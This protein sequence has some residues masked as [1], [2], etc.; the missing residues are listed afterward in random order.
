MPGW[1]AS[2]FLMN[3]IHAFG[4]GAA[5]APV[6]IANSPWPFQPRG[7]L[8]E[9]RADPLRRGLVD[10]EVARVRLGVRCW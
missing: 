9:R 10:E 2:A 6:T 8:D 4:L 1:A 7:F 3:A 5:S